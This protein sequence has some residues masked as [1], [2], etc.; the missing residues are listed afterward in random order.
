MSQTSAWAAA[1]DGLHAI[2]LARKATVGNPLEKVR[3]DLGNPG[4]A[5]Q[6]EHVYLPGEASTEE[7][8]DL[9]NAAGGTEER[10]ETVTIRVV[11]LTAR[12]DGDYVKVR[13]RLDDLADQVELAVRG[14]RTLGGSV[15]D[16]EVTRIDRS[17]GAIGEGPARGMVAEVSVR[18]TAYLS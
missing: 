14:D 2:L 17:E 13:N 4:T 3:V 15:T 6:A 1:Q 16:A 9:T 5:T 12:A 7:T 11:V 8:F 18:A 10:E